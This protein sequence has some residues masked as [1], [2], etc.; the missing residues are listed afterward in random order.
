MKVDF[1]YLDLPQKTSYIW[2]KEKKIIKKNWYALHAHYFRTCAVDV[3]IFVT[4]RPWSAL[5]AHR[6]DNDETADSHRIPRICTSTRHP[7]EMNNILY[8]TP[9]FIIV[10][11]DFVQM[12]SISSSIYSKSTCELFFFAVKFVSF[13]YNLILFIPP[14]GCATKTQQKEADLVL[15]DRSIDT[16]TTGHYWN[17]MLFAQNLIRMQRKKKTSQRAVYSNLSA[18]FRLFRL[19]GH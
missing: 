18:C 6:D 12:P 15:V 16:L 8:S 4:I 10:A 2:K 9:I 13:F 7:T 17:Q 3:C 11:I 19:H 14:F 1:P 5:G